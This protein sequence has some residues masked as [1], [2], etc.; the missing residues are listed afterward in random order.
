M[1]HLKQY[2]DQK[3]FWLELRNIQIMDAAKLDLKQ[4]QHLYEDI[5][6]DLS[7]ENLC[8]DGELRG[9]ALKKK[10]A[11]LNSAMRE[12]LIEADRHGVSINERFWA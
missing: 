8:C 12:L 4:I 9:A 3:N 10:T 5:M 6:C 2:V 11:M 1:K 7:S